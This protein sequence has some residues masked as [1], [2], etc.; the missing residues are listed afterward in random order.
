MRW[1]IAL[2]V[3]AVVAT[4]SA[5][6][7]VYHVGDEVVV[8][9]Q[10]LIHAN[11]QVVG[12]AFLGWTYRVL[13]VSDGQL[14]VGHKTPGWIAPDAVI[15]IER[16]IEH[17]T[18]EIE[19][20]PGDRN[21]IRARTIVWMNQG[22][23]DKAIGGFSEL[24]RL[25]PGDDTVW[26]DR[27]RAWMA[28]GA[29]ERAIEDY[30][31]AIK[32]H[33]WATYFNNRGIAWMLKREYEKAI[34]DWNVAL[35]L[36]A[37]FQWPH[38]LLANLYATCPDPAFRDGNKALL[39]ATKACELA[40]LRD[41]VDYEVLAAAYAELGDFDAAA[42][43]QGRA[44]ERHLTRIALDEGKARLKLYERGEPYRMPDN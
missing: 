43:W 20:H 13:E 9:R 5:A 26:N 16:A 10:T 44:N 35:T 41:A 37:K 11:G 7:D 17:F 28:K 33:P 1:A 15:P 6:Q 19:K 40:K 8:I 24:I 14:W 18:A 30:T 29:L 32:R 38:R 4:G 23:L 31:Q 22:E 34:K 27:A 12:E 21:L 2:C 25:Q 39:H 42:R 36:R 3:L